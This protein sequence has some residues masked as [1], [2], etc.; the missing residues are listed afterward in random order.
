MIEIVLEVFG[1]NRFHRVRQLFAKG[2]NLSAIFPESI[3]QMRACGKTRTSHITY[4]VALFHLDPLAYALRYAGE[5]QITRRIRSVVFNFDVP[6]IA[7]GITCSDDRSVGSRS[8]RCA[9]R[10]RIIGS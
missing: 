2:I 7:P 6:T 9:G 3:T 10:R 4:D 8:D 1:L 5:V